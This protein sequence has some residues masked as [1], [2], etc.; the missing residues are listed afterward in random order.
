MGNSASCFDKYSI[1]L[2][3]L[4]FLGEQFEEPKV[5]GLGLSLRTKERL[6][7]IWLKDGRNEKVRTN[8]SNKL[9]QFLGLDPDSV[10]LYYKEHQKSIKDQSTMKNAEGFKFM[11]QDQNN[12]R[13]R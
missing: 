4:N 2:F 7:E 12:N 13:S 3:L 6:I 10:T 5:I 9:R 8:V 11:K 1:I